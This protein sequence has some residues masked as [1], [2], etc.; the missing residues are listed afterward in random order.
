M[1]KYKLTLHEN[2]DKSSHTQIN[3]LVVYIHF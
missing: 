2:H 3:T 1:D